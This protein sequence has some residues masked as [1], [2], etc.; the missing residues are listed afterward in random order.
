[1]DTFAAGWHPLIRYALSH[2]RRE[3]PT[4]APPPRELTADFVDH[5]ID[6]AHALG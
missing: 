3:R 4:A 1:M 5:V 6:R 2:R